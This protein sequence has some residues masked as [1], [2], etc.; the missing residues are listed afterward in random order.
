M[1]FSA[2]FSFLGGTAFRMIW[3][4]ISSWLNKAQDHAFELER[5]KLQEQIDDKTH[6]RNLE[7]LRV[8][9]DLGIKTIVTQADNNIRELEVQGWLEAVKGVSK[10]SGV[11]WVD[12]WNAIIR[13]AVATWAILMITASEFALIV[14][15]ENS[16]MVASAALGIYLADRTLFKRGK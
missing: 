13:P 16:W 3:G 5:L 11:K 14:M 2:L 15:S 8:Q 6:E 7:N 9:A 1:M 12:A 10:K 4:E